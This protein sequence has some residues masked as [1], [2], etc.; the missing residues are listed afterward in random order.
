M[1]NPALSEM[2]LRGCGASA[3]VRKKTKCDRIRDHLEAGL[4]ITPVEALRM[5]GSFCLK[6]IICD[7]RRRGYPIQTEIVRYSPTGSRF[8]RYS[9]TQQKNDG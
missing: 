3:K 9:L 2:T 8:A 5:Y 4:T 7:L 1:I 6:D